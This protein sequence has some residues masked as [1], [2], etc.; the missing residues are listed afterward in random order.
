MSVSLCKT[1]SEIPGTLHLMQHVIK[2]FFHQFLRINESCCVLLETLCCGSFYKSV[3]PVPA[4]QQRPCASQSSSIHHCAEALLRVM[5]CE[6]GAA[7]RFVIKSGRERER[8]G[9]AA[10][11]DCR[12]TSCSRSQSAASYTWQ[13][14]FLG[15][16]HVEA[17]ILRVILRLSQIDSLAKCWFLTIFNKSACT[18]IDNFQQR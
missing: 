5:K 8:E 6:L 1:R 12:Q 4:A 3:E 7:F 2:M 13:L 10:R 16:G 15:V 17:S 18:K 9:A 11:G 14:L